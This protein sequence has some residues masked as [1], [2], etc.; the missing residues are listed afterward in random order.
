MIRTLFYWEQVV[1]LVQEFL[2]QMTVSGIGKELFIK[3]II[4]QLI[5]N[6][7]D[8]VTFIYFVY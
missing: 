5:V 8:G 3:V 4:Q 1:Q 2:L 7:E 6:I